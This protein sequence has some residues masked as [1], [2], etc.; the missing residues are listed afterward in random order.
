[1]F[2]INFDYSPQIVSWEMNHKL[3]NKIVWKCFDLKAIMRLLKLAKQLQVL[4]LLPEAAEQFA[5]MNGD[6]AKDHGLT[7]VWTKTET[8]L[9][10]HLDN[11]MKCNDKMIV[12]S[13]VYVLHTM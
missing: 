2:L 11:W 12:L 5:E 10:P 1:M 13:A 9:K 3:Q 8:K 4:D 6:V 7:D